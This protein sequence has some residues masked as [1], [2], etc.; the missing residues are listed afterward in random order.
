MRYGKD[1]LYIH[2]NGKAHFVSDEFQVREP[3]KH[4]PT[5]RACPRIQY[6]QISI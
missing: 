6:R 2:N 3:N 4:T 1:T 5:L